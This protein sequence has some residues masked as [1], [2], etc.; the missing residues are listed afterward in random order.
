MPYKLFFVFVLMLFAKTVNAQEKY[1][2]YLFFNPECPICQKMT[3]S[4]LETFQ[5][6]KNENRLQWQIVYTGKTISNAQIL[7]FNKEYNFNLPYTIKKN[8]RFARRLK[9]SVTPECIVLGSK[10]QVFYQGAIDNWYSAL[11]KYTSKPTEFYL[12]DAL[13]SILKNEPVKI[14]KTTA[15]G[16]FL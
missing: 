12:K 8:N 2:V 11:G 9:I 10:N 4:V 7:E 3:K 1:K 15:I 6:F 5:D 13:L 14:T 16:C